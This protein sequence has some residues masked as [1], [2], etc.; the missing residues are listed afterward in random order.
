MKFRNL[1][2]A[3]LLVSTGALGA[4]FDLPDPSIT[5][6]PNYGGNTTI[7]TLGGVTWRGPSAYYYVGECARPDS[8]GY[9]CNVLQ[10]DNVPLTSPGHAPIAVSIT[11]QEAAVLIRSGHNYWRNSDTV[12]AGQVT[13][14]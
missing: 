12:L 4:T 14:P 3:A 1:A 13:T 5:V 6:N 10:E 9:R 2:A 8:T 7:V 11:L